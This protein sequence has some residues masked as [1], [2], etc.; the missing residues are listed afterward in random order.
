[1]YI[2]RRWIK[3][4]A[5]AEKQ[6]CVVDAFQSG[7]PP[8]Y[9]PP[10][11]MEFLEAWNAGVYGCWGIWMGC[12][13]IWLCGMVGKICIEASKG[14]AQLRPCSFLW[15]SCQ[16]CHKAIYTNIHI[17]QHPYTPAFQAS[18]NSICWGGVYGG[19]PQSLSGNNLCYRDLS[20]HPSPRTCLLTTS[21]SMPSA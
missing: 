16:P 2:I 5:R 1:M 20:Q 15:V 18:K 3:V 8:Y 14:A 21:E 19:P 9:T 17:P 7:G 6:L 13:C 12:W 4:E 10:Q 11:Q